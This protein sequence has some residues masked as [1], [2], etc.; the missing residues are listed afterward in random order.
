MKLFKKLSFLVLALTLTFVV[1]ACDTDDNGDDNGDNGSD[2]DTEYTT[3]NIAEGD[4]PSNDFHSQV[5]KFIIENGYEGYD[6]EVQTL[7]TAP[8]LVS[9][10]SGDVDF[11]LELWTENMASY[12]DD[13]ADGLYEEVSINFS[14]NAQGIYIPAYI[15]ED[16]PGLQSIQ[17]LPDYKHLFPDPD[18]S[19]WDPDYDKAIVWGGPSDWEITE[20]LMRKW[21]NTDEYSELIEHFEFRPLESTAMLNAQL[22]SDYDD[23][24]GWVGYNWEP[25]SVFGLLDLVLLDDELDY[26]TETGAGNP[27]AQPVTVGAR[28]GL[29]ADHPEI[30]AFVSNYSTSS[31][32]TSQAE[33]YMMEN[34]LTAEETA[35]WWLENNT[36]VWQD[37][38]PSDVFDRVMDALE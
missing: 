1:A 22:M 17:D 10:R 24:K 29:E 26:D 28:A 20:F 15:Q 7:A 38:V 8:M 19:S 21:D 35:Q 16:N 31:L 36:D 13:L 18:T 12:Q 27:P 33:A 5:A 37:W 2:W 14:D 34:E 30:Y 3:I 6:V 25:S 11:H 9:L 32:I 4:W 23:G